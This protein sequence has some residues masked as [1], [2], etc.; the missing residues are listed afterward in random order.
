MPKMLTKLPHHWTLSLSSRNFA[1]KRVQTHIPFKYLT[2]H[3]GVGGSWNLAWLGQFLTFKLV[4]RARARVAAHHNYSHL[5][6]HSAAVVVF[7]TVV[8]HG[9]I[10]WKRNIKCQSQ[11]SFFE[12]NQRDDTWKETQARKKKKHT[13]KLIFVSTFVWIIFNYLHLY[14]ILMMMTAMMMMMMM[15]M[16]NHHWWCW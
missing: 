4:L 16:V 2:T 13:K 14:P 9:N 7:C 11:R 3:S 1:P 12:H 10:P 15:Y 5:D 8:S 6:G